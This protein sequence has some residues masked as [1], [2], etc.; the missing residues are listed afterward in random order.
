MM[1]L[2]LLVMTWVA[3]TG[4]AEP[5]IE[6]ETVTVAPIPEATETV[7]ESPEPASLNIEA[8]PDSQGGLSITITG[9]NFDVAGT[10]VRSRWSTRLIIR[11]PFRPCA[12]T[13]APTSIVPK[14]ET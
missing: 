2:A 8:R 13:D 12:T 9:V 10:K 14:T 1:R 5:T 4:N 3:C 7:T 6:T 11:S